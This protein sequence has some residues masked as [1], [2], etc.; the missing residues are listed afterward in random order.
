M[1]PALS[2][3]FPIHKIGSD[4]FNWWV[5]QVESE[6]GEDPKNSGRYRVR[7]VGVHL[8]DCNATKTEDLPWANVM[9]PASNPWSDGGVSG[10]SIGLKTGNWVVGFFLDNDQ[11]R[12]LIL[13][14]IGHTAGA[15]KLEN[16]EKDPNPD[17]TCKSFTT[18]IDPASDPYIHQPL[19]ATEKDQTATTTAA[20]SS[21]AGSTKPGQAGLPATAVPAKAAPLF[22]SAFAPPSANNPHGQKVC[23]EIANPNC[24]TEKQFQENLNKIIGDMLKANQ[25]SGGQIGDYYVSKYTG[26]LNKI[27]DNGKEYI[28]KAIKLVTSLISRIK[29]EIVKGIEDAVDKLVE[30]LLYTNEDALGNVNTGPV[31]PDLGIKPFSDIPKDDKK[32]LLQDVMDAINDVLDDIGCS[33]EDLT[34]RIADYITDLL[35]NIL[36]DAYR[37]AVC[38]V[39]TVV[40]GVINQLVDFIENSLTSILEPLSAVLDIVAEPLNLVG[41]FVNKALEILGISCDGG[42]TACES[43]T[44]KCV[45]CGDDGDTID[46]WLDDL[47]DALANGP[48]DTNTYV[49]DEAKT[50]PPT[51]QTNVSFVG[52]TFVAESSSNINL[53]PT[54]GLSITD[55]P[56]TELIQYTSS[57]IEVIEGETA[58]FTIQRFGDV[59][60]ATSVKI[61]VVPKTAKLNE[62][63]EKNFDGASLGFAAGQTEKTVSFTTLIDKEDEGDETFWIRILQGVTPSGYKV[64]FPN[65]KDFKCTII[66]SDKIP[67]IPDLNTDIVYV[68]PSAVDIEGYTAQPII[69]TLV[70]ALPKFNVAADKPFYYENEQVVFTLVGTNVQ[71]GTAYTW[72]IDV[73]A[74]DIEGG[75]LSGLFI[76][77]ENGEAQVSFT[78]AENNDNFSVD[79]PGTIPQTDENGDLILNENGEVLYN[80]EEIITNFDDL[81]EVLTLTVVETGDTG[82]IT[83]LGEND[84][85]QSYFIK[86]TQTIYQEGDK[87]CFNIFTSNVPDGTVGTWQ[88]TGDITEDDVVGKKLQGE[89]SIQNGAALVCV[90][91]ADNGVEDNTRLVTFSIVD[92]DASENFTIAPDYVLPEDV[93]EP[94]Y[95]VATDKLIYKEGE[96]ITYTITTTEVPDGTVLQWVLYGV[97]ITSEDV[98]GG[99]MSGTVVIINNTATVFVSIAEDL[100]TENQETLTFLLSG[101]NA[102]AEVILESEIEDLG[103][104]DTPLNPISPCLT[105]PVASAPITDDFGSIISIPVISQG[106]PYLLPPQVIVTGAG[107]GATA[108]PLLDE[109]GRVSEIRVTR[110]GTGYKK[111]TSQDKNLKC[112]I[113]SFTLLTPGRGYTEAPEVLINGRSGIAEAIINDKGFV[114]S[115]QILDRSFEFIGMPKVTIQ[116]G[117]GSGARV[118]PSLACLDTLENLAASGYAKIGTGKYIDCP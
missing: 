100:E 29:G 9:L 2:S 98:V 40:S 16:I 25:D 52:G 58:T 57:D 41:G 113:D 89:F 85:S 67:K 68:P 43:V 77:D 112:V 92:T 42:N 91:L 95:A 115:V 17:G 53:T 15:T 64:N 33:M 82:K 24:G 7:I 114:I 93:I 104:I 75:Q 65:G 3:L 84:N 73:D 80:E 50:N 79:A 66:D 70:P 18:F 90:T 44:K 108:I 109:N 78:L 106:C 111:N 36:M 117:G 105:K 81:D 5:G 27:I 49:C 22:Y 10:S 30:L 87:A 54:P 116:G 35:L 12:P 4:G 88:L 20:D 69:P 48:Q 97:G 13:G 6:Q 74:D 21:S 63:F 55:V 101:T 34:T 1:D 31:N 118:I 14:S 110:T 83:I 26:E 38:L 72:E 23:V 60:K 76:P 28:N 19:A 62:D 47:L 39:D 103:V 61:K 107:I 51:T 11:Q 71:A 8:K 59:T 99:K 96:V 46:D 37:G 86:A 45:D 56:V 32:A 102:F 94:S